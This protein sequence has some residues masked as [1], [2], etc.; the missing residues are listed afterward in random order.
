MHL[1]VNL[2]YGLFLLFAAHIYFV[3]KFRGGCTLGP[4]R[5]FESDALESQ[6]IL[7]SS[8]WW[9]LKIARSL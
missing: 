4:L 2:L 8:R 1:N 9:Q 5:V 7:G 3:E 6:N